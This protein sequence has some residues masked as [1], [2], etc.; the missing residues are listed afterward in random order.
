MKPI[1]KVDT[2]KKDIQALIPVLIALCIIPLVI[3][4]KDYVTDFT[5]FV[6]F[7]NQEINQIDSFEYSK[8]ILV[9]IMG[10]VA[11][12][13]IAFSEYSKTKKK[14]RPFENI[15]LKVFILWAVYLVM[16]LISGIFSQYTE[17][18]FTGGGYG[19]WQTVWVL[20]GYGM[21]FMYAYLFINTENRGLITIKFMM[22]TT[23]ML[24]FLGAM[25]TAGHNPL[26]W[27]W[28]QKMITSQSTTESITFKE[29][30]SSVI[31]TFNN[32][33]YV[34]PYVALVFPVAAAFILIKASN[35]KTKAIVCK[36]IGVL[37]A[38]GLVV[39]LVGS[40]SSAGMIAL[41]AGICFSIILILS[42]VFSKKKNED[43]E[44]EL[45]EP[46]RKLNKQL[47]IAGEIVIVFVAAGIFASRSGL[48]KNTMDKVLQGGEDTR[49]IA[50]IVNT[51]KN[52]LDVTLRNDTKFTL[53]PVVDASGAVTFTARDSSNK[54]IAVSVSPEA[55]SGE[56]LYKLADGRFSMI[57][58][59]V[60]NFNLDNKVYPGFKFND[61]PNAISWTFIYVDGKWKYYTPF[62]KLMRLHEV[63]S[64]GF[65]DHQNIANRRGFIWS[66]TIPL[67]KDYWFTGIGPNAFI[68]AFPNDDFVGSKRVGDSTTLVDKPHNAFLQTYIQTGGISAIAYAGLWLLYIIGGIR[69]FWGR[70][71]YSDIDKIGLGLLTGIFA[72]AVAGITNDTVI[73]TQNIYW[74]LLGLG[75]AVNRVISEV[76]HEKL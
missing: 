1:K 58:L 62:G 60:N 57:T 5:Q 56:K 2:T 49:N 38:A 6:W 11:A 59:S 17:L 63:E 36:G 43:S 35:D 32:P 72:F 71:H 67:L 12:L 73:G 22:V 48:V 25:Q 64:I 10:A 39:S 54:E 61:A 51:K 24:A 37:I 74:I 7:N 20:L 47:I 21:L 28:V 27:D 70:K 46:K 45:K 68:I 18:A 52:E 42:G 13:V 29:G 53:T 14:K 31:L 23:G 33:N 76:A 19:Q 41:L 69:I 8:G 40:D 65:K 55:T 15:D 50:S 30:V 75:Y 9:T 3:L 26:K 4:T 66:R 16:V 34:G 44:S